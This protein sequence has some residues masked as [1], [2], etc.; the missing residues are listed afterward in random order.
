MTLSRNKWQI[1]PPLTPTAKNE[2]S[3]FSAVMQQV[4]YNRG[5][6]TA[7]DARNFLD[8]KS[9][10]DT[11]P[12]NIKGVAEA[13]ERLAQAKETGEM[14]VVYGDYDADG[15]TASALMI[16]TLRELGFRYDYYIPDRFTEGYGLNNEA[17][18]ALK[19]KGAS[20]II[21]VDC[22]IRA[23]EQAQHAKKIGL[24]LIIT[25]HHSVGQVLPEAVA[26]INTRQ[27][28]DDYPEKNLA[29]VGIA[30]KLAAALIR[31]FEPGS[32]YRQY[33]LDLVAIGTVADMVPLTGEN[34][35]LVQSGLKLLRFPKRRGVIAL[36]GISGIEQPH[37]IQ[38][39]HIGFRLGP[40]IN[41]AG[42]L[43]S[44]LTA[45]ELLITEDQNKA[46]SL[47][48]ELDNRN[49][50][51]QRITQEI[52]QKTE[53][54]FSGVQNGYL[55]FAADPDF[56]P[57][58]VGLAASKL[59]DTYYR[60]AIIAHQGEEFTR[61]SCRSIPEFQ[62]TEALEQCSDL[63]ERF[64]GH[65]AAAGFTV[66]NHNLDALISRLKEIAR[67]QLEGLDLAPTL[68]IDAEVSLSDLT[69]DLL[70]EFDLMQPTGYGNP[71]PLLA[72][73]HLQIE[74]ARCVGSD[75]S[76][77]KL[78]VSDENKTIDAI[79]FGLGHIYDELPG[80]IDAAFYFENNEFRGTVTPQ[81]NIQDIK[82]SQAPY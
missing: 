57:G 55:L 41:A 9:H 5:Y 23:V 10:H 49:R 66:D 78:V 69:D 15:V 31:H 70:K 71:D 36:E 65:A 17:L 13:V 4:L 1:A 50:Q 67:E 82:A 48:Q 62:I 20:V 27:P 37:T 60:P 42:R 45:L 3:E 16:Q 46:I 56:N 51:R 2:L 75:G 58:V 53:E 54:Q 74:N 77:L 73:R 7:A 25:D 18:S 22:G 43:A 63:L 11:D 76:H 34:R 19:Q 52:I 40:R 80:F 24:E 6:S 59:T 32:T 21:T 29:G 28:G 12:L 35:T 26:V 30:Y 47:V 8:G 79:A 72:A 44:A 14:V 38:S 39:Q 64:G 61:A 68:S 33:L 81:L